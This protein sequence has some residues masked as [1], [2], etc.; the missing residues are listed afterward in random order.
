MKC[1]APKSSGQLCGEA[2]QPGSVFCRDHEAAPAGKRGGWLSAER[3]RR[4]RS[5]SSSMDASNVARRLWVGSAPPFD[6][7]LPKFDVLALCAQE[8]QPEHVAFHGLLIRCPIPDGV[9][10]NQQLVRVLV[11]ARNVARALGSG[12]NVLVT[13]A[14]G[15]N[16]S[17]LVASIALAHLTRMSADDLVLLM[18]TR[19]HP[20]ALSNAHFQSLL[21]RIVGQGIR[22]KSLPTP[23]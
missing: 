20:H 9:L 19:R 21:S 2:C 16:R 18:R 3:R 7:D 12:R 14:Q 22:A 15:R 6:R 11:S 13:C 4:Q 17:A 5:A 8:L 1:I 10:D 23:R